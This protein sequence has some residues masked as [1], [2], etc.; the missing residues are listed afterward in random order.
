MLSLQED[1]SKGNANIVEARLMSRSVWRVEF[2][3]NLNALLFET[4]RK[5]AEK[6]ILR[7][8]RRQKMADTQK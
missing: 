2:P 5:L 4:N 1:G 6:I 3:T 8:D 7:E